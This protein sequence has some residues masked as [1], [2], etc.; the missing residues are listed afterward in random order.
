MS[1]VSSPARCQSEHSLLPSPVH[2]HGVAL[3]DLDRERPARVDVAVALRAIAVVAGSSVAA[4]I[5]ARR[6]PIPVPVLLLLA[7]VVFGSDG[8]GAVDTEELHDLTR[9]VVVLAVALI[10]FEGGTVLN[11]RLLRVVGPVVRNLVVLGLIITPVVGALAAHAFL[12][13]GWRLS[14]LF[15]ALVCVTGPSVITPLLKAVRVNDRLRTTLMGEGIIID[16]LGALLTLFL[17][18][19]AVAESFD[20]AGPTRWV[21]E[22]VT[23]GVLAGAA[24]ALGILGVT[25]VVKRLSSRELSLLVVAGAVIAFATAESLA[26]EA[27]LTA[28]VVMGIA[29]GNLNLPHRESLNEFQESIVVFLVGSVYVLL[30]AGI[31]L[32]ELRRIFPEALFV[33]AAL[34][35]V[36]RPLLVVLSSRGSNLS[37]RERLFLS[38]VAPRGVVAAS[39]AGV[40][41]VEATPRLASDGG[42][43]VA[44]VF[45]VIAMTIAVQ[46]AYAGILSRWLKVDPMTTVIAGAGAIGR[47]L[48]S[49]LASMGR[50]VVL[51]D[52]DEESVTRAREDGFDVVLGDVANIE[53]LAKARL[54]EATAFVI[55]TPDA[56]RA[57]LAARIAT[58]EFGCTNVVAR[59]DEPR[60][61]PVFRD[62]GVTVVSPSE[63]TAAEIATALGEPQIAGLLAA[64]EEE[65]EAIQVVV[66]NPAAAVPIEAIPALKGT[67]AV[68]L[69][70]G[71]VSI[72][73]DGKT[74]LQIGDS[75]TLFGR[76]ADLQRARS[77]LSLEG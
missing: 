49:K 66:T 37:W 9:V 20:A 56:D 35:L 42:P 11:W 75:V 12:G 72:M 32:D 77:A 22:R 16:P 26:H 8:L 13:F 21:V 27:G 61:I 40:V 63:A 53:T 39:L 3:I 45:V 52:A 23:I 2:G 30:A 38:A 28:M 33:V 47:H 58:T 67:L 24:G 50:D 10:V 43:L 41:A 18:Q 71:A 68:L 70:R 64:I 4:Q 31:D 65:F 15:G 6:L 1:P 44:L 60:N 19:V 5:I 25:R 54:G 69:R 74:R 46:S 73:P 17:L 59:V 14:A 57:L 62:L 36:G 7:G 34:V 55:T 48:A 76:S 29:A 51:I